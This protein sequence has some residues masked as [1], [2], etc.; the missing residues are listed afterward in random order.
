LLGCGLGMEVRGQQNNVPLQRDFYI[1]LERNASLLGSR[2]HSGLKP[3]IESRAD[4]TN[5]MGHR[6]DS[7][8][9]YYG[10]TEKLF[11]DHLLDVRG[12][13]YRLML[14]PLFEQ[15]YGWERGDP[16]DYADT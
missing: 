11:R 8:K 16:T 12:D 13:G 4:L 10:F 3:V 14:D 2:V 1:D 7:G 15:Q 6:V 9:Y 5:V